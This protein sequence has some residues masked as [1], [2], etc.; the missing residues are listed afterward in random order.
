MWGDI[1]LTDCEHFRHPHRIHQG[2]LI[3]VSFLHH[4]Y[5][6]LRKCRPHLLC[7]IYTLHHLCQLNSSH[8]RLHTPLLSYQFQRPLLAPIG[9]TMHECRLSVQSLAFQASSSVFAPSLS[10]LMRCYLPAAVVLPLKCTHILYRC[11]HLRCCLHSQ[12]LLVQGLL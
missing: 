2:L 11:L 9:L 10:P 12:S 3:G 7:F 4:H 5:L 1:R 6:R 8:L